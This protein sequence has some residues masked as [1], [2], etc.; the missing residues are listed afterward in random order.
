M[1]QVGVAI[2]VMQVTLFVVARILRAAASV[3]KYGCGH[4]GHTV[5][6]CPTWPSIS[7]ADICVTLINT[8]M[9]PLIVWAWQIL[10]VVHNLVSISLKCLDLLRKSFYQWH[11]LSFC[12][13]SASLVAGG[14]NNPDV[15]SL[16]FIPH[17]ITIWLRSSLLMGMNFISSTLVNYF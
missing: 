10:H 7:E 11:A 9:P 6:W 14:P 8:V 13:L 3:F 15:I 5:A 1:V 12:H 2:V 16:N 4:L 17:L